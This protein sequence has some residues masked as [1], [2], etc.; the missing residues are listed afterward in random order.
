MKSALHIQI[1]GSFFLGLSLLL[2]FPV[3]YWHVAFCCVEGHHQHEDHKEHVGFCEGEVESCPL[4]DLTVLPYSYVAKVEVAF[5]EGLFAEKEEALFH[6]DPVIP[7]YSHQLR[8][9]P[10]A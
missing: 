9:P 2:H 7:L 1:I 10:L 8:G 6:P 4:C 5:Y 3:Q